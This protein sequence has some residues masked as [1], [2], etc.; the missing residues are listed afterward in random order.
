MAG[1]LRRG[2]PLAGTEGDGLSIH[3]GPRGRQG[4]GTEGEKGRGREKVKYI[5]GRGNNERT[6]LDRV[7]EGRRR[8]RER[9]SGGRGEWERKYTTRKKES[10]GRD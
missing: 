3:L 2:T 6:E 9:E 4:T 7:A 5:A 8:E 10:S 1:V